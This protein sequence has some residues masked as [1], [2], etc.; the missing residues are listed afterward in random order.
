MFSELSRIGRDTDL[1]G[2]LSQLDDD[3]LVRVAGVA[4]RI[5]AIA[6]DEILRRAIHR[7]DI[8]E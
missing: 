8:D 5:Y 1:T 2:Y 4:Y 6:D 3:A 7:K